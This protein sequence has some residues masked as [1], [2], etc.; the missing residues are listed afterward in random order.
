MIHHVKIATLLQQELVL[1]SK[2]ATMKPTNELLVIS[3]S[4]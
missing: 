3:H 1:R 2:Q 4:R